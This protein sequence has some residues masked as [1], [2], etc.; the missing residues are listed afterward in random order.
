MVSHWPH[1]PES[2]LC[3]KLGNQPTHQTDSCEKICL[4]YEDIGAR[5]LCNYSVT[6]LRRLS[7]QK[8][9]SL[10]ACGVCQAEPK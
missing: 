5:M 9:N 4:M 2:R 10:R 7:S 6:C 8:E 3:L 1:M